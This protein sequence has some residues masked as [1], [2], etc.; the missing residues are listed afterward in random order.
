MIRSHRSAC[1]SETWRIFWKKSFFR[2]DHEEHACKCWDFLS[3]SHSIAV[4][5]GLNQIH[6]IKLRVCSDES[7]RSQKSFIKKISSIIQ[8][9]K[10][11]K[12]EYEKSIPNPRMKNLNRN[13]EILFNEIV[14]SECKRRN[15]EIMSS[16]DFHA[17]WFLN[18]FAV[19]RFSIFLFSK[20]IL[21]QKKISDNVHWRQTEVN[22]KLMH[23]REN[24][25]LESKKISGFS[26]FCLNF[27]ILFAFWVSSFS[28][29][30]KWKIF[31]WKFILVG[32]NFY[33]KDHENSKDPTRKWKSDW[34]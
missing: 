19:L 32:Q 16:F 12:E 10:F 27:Y 25:S 26:L 31:C 15:V 33:D 6:V 23:I 1:N 24:L 30:F 20:F 2:Y 21:F 7:W 14:F 22:R 18:Y 3:W 5:I 9:E 28:E 34:K 13:M 29:V 8:S 11:L 17:F 4:K